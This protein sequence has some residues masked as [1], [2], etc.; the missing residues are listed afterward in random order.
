MELHT[1]WGLRDFLKPSEVLNFC[2]LLLVLTTIPQPSVL[3]GKLSAC[4]S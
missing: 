2:K 1:M 4:L 3:V